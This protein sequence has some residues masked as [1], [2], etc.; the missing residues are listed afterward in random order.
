ML[1]MATILNLLVKIKLKHIE[2]GVMSVVLLNIFVDLKRELQEAVTL[3]NL[4][5]DQAGAHRASVELCAVL[6]QE[7]QILARSKN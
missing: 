2:V 5:G 7:F 3:C 1:V 6:V 4:L